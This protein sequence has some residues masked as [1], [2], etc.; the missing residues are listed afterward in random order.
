MQGSGSSL[1]ALPDEALRCV[2]D[3]LGTA[4]AFGPCDVAFVEDEN[5]GRPRRAV[6]PSQRYASAV[7]LGAT[8]RRL[9]LFY[10][11]EYVRCIDLTLAGPTPTPGATL[12]RALRRFQRVRCV[13]QDRSCPSYNALPLAVGGLGGGR[14]EAIHLSCAPDDAFSR[15]LLEACPSLATVS[16]ECPRLAS[17]L[18]LGEPRL[19]SLGAGT[20]VRGLP[21]SLRRLRLAHHSESAS[22]QR[23]MWGRLAEVGGSLRDLEIELHSLAPDVFV[24]ALRACQSLERLTVRFQ[25]WGASGGG[26]PPFIASLPPSLRELEVY[27]GSTGR[28]CALE[29][30]SLAHL[31]LLARLELGRLNTVDWAPLM[32]VAASLRSLRLFGGNTCADATSALAMMPELRSL[33]LVHTEGVSDAV[34]AA[35]LRRPLLHALRVSYCSTVSD[36]GAAA[37]VAGAACGASLRSLEFFECEHVGD[38]VSCAVAKWLPNVR[39]LV[40]DGS[41]VS[42]AGVL[43]LSQGCRRLVTLH[44]AMCESVGDGSARAVGMLGSLEELMMQHTKVSMDGGVTALALGCCRRA[45]RRLG[46][47]SFRN[48][49][50]RRRESLEAAFVS[51]GL[52][53]EYGADWATLTAVEALGG[54]VQ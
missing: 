13:V 8:C 30:D 37:A 18:Q 3:A 34:V 45:L 15:A 54:S 12:A 1:P 26:F 19:R 31:P 6:G 36:A 4:A 11:A 38:A 21:P 17:F 2:F 42:D 14:I 27:D 44:L 28:V 47:E 22:V 39:R 40:L 52:A 5:D 50:R 53:V 51:R 41:A 25:D 49:D 46:L 29:A 33:T 16:L 24:P 32:R 9:A 48:V 7:A 43:A 23:A 10:R 20:L 35:A